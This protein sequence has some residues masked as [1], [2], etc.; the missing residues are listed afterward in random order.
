MDHPNDWQTVNGGSNG[1]KGKARSNDMRLTKSADIVQVKAEAVAKNASANSASPKSLSKDQSGSNSSLSSSNLSR[2]SSPKTPSSDDNKKHTKYDEEVK[3]DILK[4]TLYFSCGLLSKQEL[5]SAFNDVIL[6]DVW[7]ILGGKRNV[8]IIVNKVRSTKEPGFKGDLEHA[9]VRIS[10][11]EVVNILCKR[12]PDGSAR[13]EKRE[14]PRAPKT[15]SAP[16][17][18]GSVNVFDLPPRKKAWYEDDD[19]MFPEEPLPEYEIIKLEPLLKPYFIR[20]TSPEVIAYLKANDRD[21]EEGVTLDFQAA[22]AK[23]A[24]SGCANHVLYFNGNVPETI[25]ERDIRPIFV[26]FAHDSTTVSEYRFGRERVIARLP[27][28][29]FVTGKDR[30]GRPQRKMLIHFD[31]NSVDAQDA[32]I[33][34]L[35]FSVRGYDLAVDFAPRAEIYRESIEFER[36]QHHN[37]SPANKH[38]RSHKSQ[39]K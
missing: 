31:G 27:I 21:S 37:R 32:R 25:T 15:V 17:L 35:H 28:V 18:G 10:D 26:P 6:P 11:V 22:L 8:Q 14:K 16:N 33:M 24:R 12:N 29:R 19:E 20:Y 2:S 5:T 13:E 23:R 38:N 7:K 3:Q 34:N 36:Q 1:N 39:A 30:E 4:N 9:F